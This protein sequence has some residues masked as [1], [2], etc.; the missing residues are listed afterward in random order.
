MDSLTHTVLG[1]CVGELITGSKIGKKALLIGALVNNIPDLDVI[2]YLWLS[3]SEGLLGHRGITHAI[4]FNIL[5][6][7]FLAYLLK[8][9][10]TN[11]SFS[12]NKWLLFVGFELFLHLF[13]DTFN[14]Y[15]VGLFEPFNATRIS[16]NAI[17][18][19]D[20]LFTLP[21]LVAAILLFRQKNHFSRLK[22]A[23]TSL[24]ISLFYLI[25]CGINKMDAT[26]IT[27]RNISSLAIF[28]DDYFTAPT[29][30]NNLLWYLVIKDKEQFY[31]GYYS[32]FDKNSKIIFEKINKND[33]LLTPFKNT[34]DVQNLIHFSQGYYSVSKQNSSIVFNDIRFGRQEDWSNHINNKNIPFNFHFDLQKDSKNLFLVQRGRFETLKWTNISRQISRIFRDF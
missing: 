25:L 24:S 27:Q 14:V 30:F 29:P 12:F 15:G 19:I 18:I 23:K 9:I 4:F 34:K 7:F 33:V 3:P 28:P 31:M 8:K 1:A 26:K 13:I 10:L 22:I 16:F 6:A 20:P 32:V 17:F 5:L 11:T 21:M 2:S